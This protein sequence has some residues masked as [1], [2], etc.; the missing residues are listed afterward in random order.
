MCTWE[1]SSNIIMGISFLAIGLCLCSACGSDSNSPYN[2]PIRVTDPYIE[3]LEKERKKTKSL[4]SR[5]LSAPS[6]SIYK[7]II[8]SDIELCLPNGYGVLQQVLLAL[9]KDARA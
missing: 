6:T 4:V 3:K 9:G 7:K 1:K 5:L 2:P 8:R